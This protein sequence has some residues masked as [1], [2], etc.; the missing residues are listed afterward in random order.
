MG[1]VESALSKAGIAAVA[2]ILVLARM[3]RGRHGD[4]AVFGFTRPKLVPAFVLRSTTL[5]SGQSV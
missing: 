5:A 2:V 1:P 4:M 3:R